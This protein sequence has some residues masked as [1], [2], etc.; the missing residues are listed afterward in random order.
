MLALMILFD[1]ELRDEIFMLLKLTEIQNYTQFTNLKGS[2]VHGKKEGSVS[3]P[4]ANEIILLIVNE[5]QKLRLCEH[6]KNFK[7]EREPTP[8]ILV[9]DWQLKDV[10]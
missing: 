6:I 7:T 3:W 5:E 10:L 4:G 2:S 8:G 9:F 1:S